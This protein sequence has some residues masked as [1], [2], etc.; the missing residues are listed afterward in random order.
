MIQ[1]IM[2]ENAE[3]RTTRTPLSL[4]DR[5]R[6]PGEREAWDRFVE[7]YTPFLYYWAHRAGLTDDDATD[8]VQDV[9]ALLLTKLPGFQYDPGKSFRA[10]LR[11]VTLNRWRELL[12]RRGHEA[13]GS[14]VDWSTLPAA[15]RTEEVWEADY[16]RHV[17]RRA[18]ELMQRDFAPATWKACWEVV[19]GERPAADVAAELGMTV[20]AVHAAKFRVLAR[21][22]EDLAGLL[23]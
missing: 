4:L 12:R 7:L 6:Q 23:D 2:H 17:A 22:R 21:L 15:D 13:T 19:V 11:T 1:Y 20:G 16:Q 3:P 9:F 14:A 5:L 18:L 8:L 10:W